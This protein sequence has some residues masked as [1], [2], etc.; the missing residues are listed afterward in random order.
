MGLYVLWSTNSVSAA[1]P[2]ASSLFAASEVSRGF[3]TA[4]RKRKWREFSSSIIRRNFSSVVASGTWSP[5]PEPDA[6]EPGERPR[7]VDRVL[8]ALV[9]EAE[10]QLQEVHAQHPLDPD[11]PA[12]ALAGIVE[13][14]DRGDQ[15]RPGHGRVLGPR[16]ASRLVARLLDASSMSAKVVCRSMAYLPFHR[17][18]LGILYQID[19]ISAGRGMDWPACGAPSA[20][21]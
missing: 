1:L 2:S 5:T 11:G 17:F 15:L 16:N 8:D 7:V 6:H 21:N 14:L 19:N 12:A 13:G 18:D 20:A 3:L 9:G 4:L 10:P